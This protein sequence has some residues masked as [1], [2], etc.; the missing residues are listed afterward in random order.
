MTFTQA[1]SNGF[2][3]YAD[4]SG[5]ASRGEFWYWALFS[6]LVSTGVNLID[7]MSYQSHHLSGASL[8]NLITLLLVLP[9]LAV[10]VRRLHDLDKSGWWYFIILVPLVG[11]I[12]L[13]V[14]SATRGTA[15]TNRFGQEP[16]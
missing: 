16:V 10:N 9:G 11:F 14:W 3:H 4:F 15:G 5:R 7:F 1:V 8:P 13:L 6:F 2:R 12:L